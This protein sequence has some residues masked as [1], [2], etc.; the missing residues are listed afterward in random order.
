[1]VSAQGNQT[2]VTNPDRFGPGLTEAWVRNF[3]EGTS[4]D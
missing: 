3:F 2:F 4:D 1:M